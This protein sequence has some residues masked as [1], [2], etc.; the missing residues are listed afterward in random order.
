MHQKQNI[1]IS[2]TV[3]CHLVVCLVLDW[4]QKENPLSLLLISFKEVKLACY[5]TWCGDT[6]LPVFSGCWKAEPLALS[7]L[8]GL[9][10]TV[11]LL[12]LPAQQCCGF[13]VLSCCEASVQLSQPLFPAL[14]LW[15]PMCLLDEVTSLSFSV[16]TAGT[17][18]SRCALGGGCSGD[19][20]SVIGH[21][22]GDQYSW[23][24]KSTAEAKKLGISGSQHTSQH[25]LMLII[26]YLCLPA[27]TGKHYD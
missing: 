5:C 13:A 23:W 4:Y 9:P 10:W 12:M 11:Y 7:S 15:L 22:E 18:H 24:C 3:C 16:G 21:S 8:F 27:Y 17:I 20:H 19:Q 1:F 25:F 14:K 26:N 6:A 2:N